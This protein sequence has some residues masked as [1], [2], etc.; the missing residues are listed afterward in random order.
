MHY[1]T[2]VTHGRAMAAIM[3]AWMLAVL[4]TGLM[5]AWN[6]D[7]DTQVRCLWFDIMHKVGFYLTQ[8]QLYL[9]TLCLITPMYGR[10][11]CIT[12]SLY[13]SEP[14]VTQFAPENQSVQRKKLQE[15]K[16]ATTIGLVL[17][18][19]LICY[20]PLSIYNQIVTRLYEAPF[21]FGIILGNRIL[22]IIFKVQ[23]FVN[24]YVYGWK[25]PLFW[26]VFLKMLR[27]R[28]RPAAGLDIPA[29]A[30]H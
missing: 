24:P 22:K 7:V 21:P 25:H 19:Y 3:I 13:Q 26:K 17:G 5:I 23:C 30:R 15:R 9:I 16:I 29:P 1:I 18:I 14:H 11:G 6:R 4:E 2:I 12:W 20:V 8:G 27:I 28:N 10:I